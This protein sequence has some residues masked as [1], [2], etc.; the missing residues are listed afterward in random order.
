MAQTAAYQLLEINVISAQDLPRVAKPV[1]AYAVGWVH[2]DRKLTTQVDEEGHTNPTWNEKFVFRVD[3]QFLNSDNAVVMIEIYAEGWL[4]PVLVGTVGVLVSNLLPTNRKP[5]PRFVPLQIRRPSGR[6]QGILNIGVTLLDSTMRSMPLY[7]ELSSSDVGYYDL[8][9]SRK[10]KN[11]ISDEDREKHSPLGTTRLLTLQ[12][13]Q[14]E[15]NDSAINDYAYRR[16]VKRYR[17]DEQDSEVGVRKGGAFNE[18]SHFSD[19]YHIPPPRS[20]DSSTIDGC[21]EISG[22]EAMR[23]KIQKWRMELAPAFEDYGEE[24]RKL[25]Q[26]SQRER[27]T[28]RRGAKRGGPHSCFGTVFGCEITITCTRG[29]RRRKIEDGKT[30]QQSRLTASSSSEVTYDESFI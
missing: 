3:D 12:R 8:M 10:N 29:N 14:S 19:M 28:P 13:R 1:R 20:V 22:T 7:S 24:R 6:P 16:N 26:S 9:E 27:Q 18:D 23:T 17:Y 15:E 30:R 4:S 2:P 25:K 21:S 11:A 5:K